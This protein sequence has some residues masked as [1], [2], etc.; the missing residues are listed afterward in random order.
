[1]NNPYPRETIVER[2]VTYTVD[3]GGQFRP[4][5]EGAGLLGQKSLP[6][7]DGLAKL[8]QAPVVQPEEPEGEKQGE[9]EQDDDDNDHADGFLSATR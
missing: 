3:L 8:L 9:N 1:M 5:R 6:V 4:G 2:R 7:A